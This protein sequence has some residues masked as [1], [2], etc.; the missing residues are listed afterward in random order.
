MNAGARP[1]EDRRANGQDL[2][3]HAPVEPRRLGLGAPRRAAAHDLTGEV[4]HGVGAEGGELGPG[5]GRAEIEADGAHP[6]Q[7]EARLMGEADDLVLTPGREAEPR[8]DKARRP[9]D[10][11][12]HPSAPGGAQGVVQGDHAGLDDLGADPAVADHR[13]VAALAQNLL[14]TLAGVTHPRGL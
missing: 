13:R 7:A 10:D 14:H 2:V 3:H 11:E 9:G 4:N 1:V 6:G 8:A 12:A 5:L